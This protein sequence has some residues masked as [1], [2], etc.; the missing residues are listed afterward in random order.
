MYRILKQWFIFFV[1]S[2]VVVSTSG[3]VGHAQDPSMGQFYK[4]SERNGAKM[5]ADLVFL[6]PAGVVATALGTALFI[7]SSP[8]TILG[9]NTEEASEELIKKPGRFT[10]KRPLGDF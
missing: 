8:F 6:R 10:F 3:I 7:V 1:I 4:K 2:A 5:A 9:D